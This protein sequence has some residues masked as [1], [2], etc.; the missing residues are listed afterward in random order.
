M[1]LAILLHSSKTMVPTPASRP[2]TTPDFLAEA[3][4][5]HGYIKSLT[6]EQLVKAMHISAKLAGTVHDT[7]ESWGSGE[8][9]ATIEVFRG[10]IYSG[11]RALDFS[12]TEKD[13]A[14]KHLKIFSG[15]Y[16]VLRPYDGIYP[17]RLEA[18]YTFP[19]AAFKNLYTFWGDMLKATV[20]DIDS[21]LNLTS[22][23]YEKL[24][25]P[26]IDSSKIITPRFLTLMPGSDEPKFVVVHVKIARGAFARWVIKRGIDSIE[27]LEKFDDLGY[28]YDEA[29]STPLQPVFICRDFKGIGLSQRLV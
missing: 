12:P 27:G 17:Y 20:T 5:L 22:V 21:I 19:D 16:G 1:S 25:L 18:A 13:F 10:D 11:L 4:Q 6:T 15:L 3:T 9:S 23:E 2:L 8:P 24:L 26:F 29:L 14:Q 7:Y 28:E